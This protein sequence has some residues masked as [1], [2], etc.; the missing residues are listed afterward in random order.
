MEAIVL[1][2]VI[3]ALIT[4]CIAVSVNVVA[5]EISRQIDIWRE[6]RRDK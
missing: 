6:R 4:Y 3:G 2:A 5:N 1:T